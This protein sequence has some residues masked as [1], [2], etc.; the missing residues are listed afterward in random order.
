MQTRDKKSQL[1][2]LHLLVWVGFALYEQAVLLI[3]DTFQFNLGPV[4]LYYLLNAALFY[5]FSSLVLQRLF[6]R[7]RYLLG[8]LGTAALLGTYG[9]A[10]SEIY[11]RLLPALNLVDGPPMSYQQFWTLAVY[12]GMFFV[13]VSGGYWFAGNAIRLAK[14]QREQERQLREAERN[15]LES[16]LAVLRSQINPHFLFNTLNFLYAQ[17]YP[18]S[19]N[20]AKAVLLLSDTMRYALHEHVNGK[21]ML[22]QEIEHIKNYIAINQ[23]RFNNQLQIDFQVIGNTQFMMIL[24]LVLLTFVENCFKHGELSDATNPLSIRL[25]VAQH[26]LTFQTRNK[27]RSGPKEKSTGIGLVNTTRRLDLSYPDR[28]QLVLKDEPLAYACTLTIAL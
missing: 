20:A 16:E 13:L 3:T 10:R 22:A 23:L 15:L 11:V 24:P 7:R 18:L 8:A 1:I 28:Y 17:V 14:Q 26:I 25:E 27:K 2:L 6:D 19:E 9:L 4:L 21:V 12:R 5:S